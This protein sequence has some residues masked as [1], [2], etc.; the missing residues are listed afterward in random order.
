MPDN[1]PLPWPCFE[2]LEELQ[3][4]RDRLPPAPEPDPDWVDR[5]EIYLADGLAQ[6]FA[7][8]TDLLVHPDTPTDLKERLAL[9]V[10]EIY[11]SPPL[12]T[13]ERKR[14]FL[15]G[16]LTRTAARLLEDPRASLELGEFCEA[17]PDDGRRL[18]LALLEHAARLWND[19]RPGRRER[20]KY[21]IVA[22]AIANTSFA[23]DAS[24]LAE[25][26]RGLHDAGWK[27]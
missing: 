10:R 6:W 11:F 23:C 24:H 1:P 9:R 16:I 8:V 17:Y 15:L 25:L 5:R 18:D 13:K 21:A 20:S 22:D 12:S 14:A 4:Q 2:D 26:R 27:K 7:L 19:R 3:A